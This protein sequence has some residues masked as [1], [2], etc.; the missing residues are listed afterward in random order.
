MATPATETSMQIFNNLHLM[1]TLYA[2]IILIAG[3]ILTK[4]I[5]RH[6]GKIAEKKLSAQQSMLLQ[7]LLFYSLITLVLIVAL[8]QVGFK[9]GIILGA[10][11][12]LTVAIG[13]AA[14]T[15]VSNVISGIFLLIE[16]P[17]VIGESI[18]I[19]G[20]V[21]KVQTL[22]LLSLKI[23]TY[24]N[25]L[26]RIPNSVVIKSTIININ[27][28]R[29]RR[30]DLSFG[31]AYDSDLAKV[32]HVLLE[33]AKTINGINNEPLPQVYFSNFS[34]SS[35][36]LKYSVWVNTADYARMKKELAFAVKKE[37]NKHAIEMPFPQVVVS[38]SA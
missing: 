16:R 24:D 29:T 13:F 4:L 27:R 21:G 19:E 22:D 33:L 30:I 12:V 14:Q 26:V 17:F 25:R 37:F 28:N 32:E 35:I 23:R 36:D 8:Q 6:I 34:A 3:F 11:G 38:K 1:N 5:T 2:C 9:L 10:A 7:K 18:Q 20:M 15:S 31:V